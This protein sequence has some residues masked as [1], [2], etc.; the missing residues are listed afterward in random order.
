MNAPDLPM[1][2]S[3]HRANDAAVILRVIGELDTLTAPAV[4]AQLTAAQAE[5]AA[6]TAVVL[7]LSDLT[8][9]SSAGL[10]LLVMHHEQCAE[11]GNRL[12]VVTGNNRSVLRPVRITGLDTMLEL[13][14]TVSDATDATGEHR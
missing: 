14:A 13:V 3:V 1:R 2:I 6:P 5:L 10:A 12:L 9:M 4:D 11:Q 7:D 8:F